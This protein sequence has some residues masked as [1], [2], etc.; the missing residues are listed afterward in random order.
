MNQSTDI[1]GSLKRAAI[2]AWIGLLL[3]LAGPVAYVVL[4]YSVLADQAWLRS[5]GL[6]AWIPMGLGLLLVFY[7]LNRDSRWRVRLPGLVS[8]GFAALFIYAFYGLAAL[9]AAQGF[10]ELD[11]APE[12]TVRDHTKHNVSLTK[13]L[14]AGPVLLVFYRGHW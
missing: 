2:P 8:M 14:S 12:F 10:D 4:G 3:I 9:P 13:Q 6:P 1:K 5:S 11:T 7:A